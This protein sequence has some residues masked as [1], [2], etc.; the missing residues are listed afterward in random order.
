MLA[1]FDKN[2]ET[3]LS[4]GASS[5]GLGTVIIQEGKPVTSSLTTMS[6]SQKMY[7]N[8]E[9]VLLAIV[10]GAQKFHLCVWLQSYRQNRTQN[11]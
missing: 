7:A 1:Y 2:K 9:R 4:V 8:I 11:T 5:T 10:W 3:V 6:A